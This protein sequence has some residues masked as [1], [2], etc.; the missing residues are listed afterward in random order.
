[1]PRKFRPQQQRWS[2]HGIRKGGTLLPFGYSAVHSLDPNVSTAFRSEASL[3]TMNSP[4][5]PLC[6]CVSASSP[7]SRDP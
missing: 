6:K 3:I 2:A 4:C 5:P 1:M 7:S